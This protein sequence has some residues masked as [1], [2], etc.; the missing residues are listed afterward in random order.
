MFRSTA[1]A[2]CS[3]L[4]TGA[5]TAAEQTGKN[6][7]PQ[8]F[9]AVAIS[10]GGPRTTGGATTIEITI[11]RWSTEAEAARLI[12]VMKSKGAEALLE[13][14]RGMKPVGTIQTPGNLAYDLHFAQQ[15]SAADGGRRIFLATDRPISYWED[16]AQ[17]RTINYP[18]TFI[19]LRMNGQGEGEGKLA[20][21]TK[22]DVAKSGKTIELVN[23]A[24]QPIQL[25]QV[26][27]AGR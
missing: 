23:Y 22:I 12:E 1:I 21:A 15:E 10:T 4:L 18:F 26:K 5:L 2:L 17:P 14:L 20:L 8:R 7:L 6:T 11:N 25:N 27:L 24:T 3:V 16:V 13:V 19:E 9:T